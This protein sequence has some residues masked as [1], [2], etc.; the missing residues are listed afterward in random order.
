MILQMPE[1]KTQAIDTPE[2]QSFSLEEIVKVKAEFAQ[3][4][5]GGPVVVEDVALHIAALGGFPGP[6]VKFWHKEVGYGPCC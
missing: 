4:A 2:I 6:F 1:L 5:C 3:K